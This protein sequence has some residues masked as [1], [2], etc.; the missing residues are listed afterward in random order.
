MRDRSTWKEIEKEEKEKSQSMTLGE[1]ML[2]DTLVEMSLDSKEDASGW[3]EERL[4]AAGRRCGDGGE[5]GRKERQAWKKQYYLNKN[6][7]IT[8][9]F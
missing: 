8:P 4:E 6:S 5:D 2:S 1:T 7:S 3:W 9:G